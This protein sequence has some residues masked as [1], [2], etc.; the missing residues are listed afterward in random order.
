MLQKSITWAEP[1]SY[2]SGIPESEENWVLL[3]SSMKTDFSGKKS[4]LALRSQKQVKAE[5]F[6]ALAGCLQSDT[7]AFDEAWFGYVGYDMRH[8]IERLP[9]DSASEIELPPLWMVNYRLILVFDH[10]QQQAVAY[11]K[12]ESDFEHIP[13]PQNVS[14][15]AASVTSLASNMT[16]ESYLK[17]VNTIQEA[18]VRGDLYQANLTRKFYG[19]I[20]NDFSSFTI[21]KSLCQNSPAPYSAFL[22]LGD[23]AIIS[24]SPEQFLT[25]D[26]QGQ[27]STRP[28]KGSA[29]RATNNEQDQ[30]MKQQLAASTKDRAENLMIVDL[31]R[32]DLSRSCDIGSVVTDSLFD[33]TSYETIHH[34]SSTIMGQKTE[35]ASTLDLVKGCFPPGSMTGTPKIKAMEVCSELEQQERG[36]YSGAIGW[37]G[38]DGSADLSVVIRTLLIQGNRFEFQVGGAIVYDSV[39]EQEW[40]ET[41]VKAKAIANVLGIEGEIAEL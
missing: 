36:V 26:P 2:A 8:D 27:V 14:S 10:E 23:N 32:N 30:E 34:M 19:E 15:Q 22:K 39:P 1:L 28:I 4:I 18:I 21:F 6:D 38:G 17:K 5:A 40:R 20:A 7:N 16:K 25:V 37:F 12:E 9:K 31:M 3:Y 33:I 41:L 35:Q 11:A 24:S 13:T 29:P